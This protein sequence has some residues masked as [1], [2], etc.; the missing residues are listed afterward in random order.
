VS[1]SVILN[2]WDTTKVSAHMSMACLAAIRK[3]TDEPY[4]IIVV[5]N[6][7]T[8]GIRDEYHVLQPFKEITIPLTNVY[9]SYNIGAKHATTDKFMFIQNDVY[10]HE[11]TLNKLSAY[12]DG[13][14][15]VFPQQIPISRKDVKRIHKIK[16][17][18]PTHIGQRDAGLL[19]ITRSAFKKSGGWDDRYQNLLGEAA[20]YHRIDQAGL[21]W[22]DHTNALIT[23]IM[24]ASNLSKDSELYNKEMEHDAKILSAR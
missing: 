13:W 1:F 18:N 20:F 15:V 3:F 16:N 11:R 21:S 24:A 14:D 12:L 4:E 2:R 10:V 23:H 19:G 17:Y 6:T 8:H 5:N 7:S 22:T 9:D